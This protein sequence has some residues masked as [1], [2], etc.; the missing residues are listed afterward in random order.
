[1][2]KAFVAAVEIGIPIVN[3]VGQRPVMR[4]AYAGHRFA[5]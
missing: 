3:C 4:I 1:M 5:Q 2:E